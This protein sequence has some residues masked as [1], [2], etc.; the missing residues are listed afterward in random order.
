MTNP[1]FYDTLKVEGGFL[2]FT[3]H[4]ENPTY[5]FGYFLGSLSGDGS[6]SI[7]DKHYYTTK[8]AGNDLEV[9]TAFKD[10]VQL[11]SPNLNV[12]RY[13]D[14]RC[15]SYDSCVNNK[16]LAYSVRSLIGKGASQKT[17]PI[18]NNPKYL[19]GILSGLID[20]DGTVRSSG[21][22]IIEVTSFKLLES[23]ALSINLLIDQMP[24]IR[25]SHPEGT[26]VL[27]GREYWCKQR[28]ALAINGDILAKLRPY[29]R[30]KVLRKAAKMA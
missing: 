9:H 7:K 21:S 11:V 10:F 12:L 17:F 4:L 3:Q 20:T 24:P 28:Y 14:L 16:E 15:N 18:L 23:T 8:I 1:P 26:Y 29:L 27:S 22:V 25:I 19:S 6:T 30:L 13:P 2:T 5:D